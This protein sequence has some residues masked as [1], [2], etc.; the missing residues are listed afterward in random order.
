[1]LIHIQLFLFVVTS[2]IVI[3]GSFLLKMIQKLQ[4]LSERRLRLLPSLHVMIWSMTRQEAVPLPYLLLCHVRTCPHTL[5]MGKY[6]HGV[7]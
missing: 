4:F 5:T 6:T 7:Y 1:M 2:I 3:Q